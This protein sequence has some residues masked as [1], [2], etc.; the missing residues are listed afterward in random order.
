M[1]I[2]FNEIPPAGS[3]YE[4]QRIKGL[5][6]P[7]EFVVLGP[8]RAHCVLTRKG[9]CQVELHGRLQMTVELVCDR[10]LC[11]YGHAVDI[12]L[13][14]LFEVEATDSWRVKELEYRIPDLDTVLL[15]EPELDLDDILRQQVDLALPMKKLCSDA[16]KGICSRCGANRNQ[17]P[18]GCPDTPTVSPFAALAH[19]NNKA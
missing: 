19:L 10:C 8:V 6:T 12:E 2:R 1:L 4:I 13:H 17:A 15:D 5:D 9:D 18:C 11:S 16:C 7:R 14:L 3:H